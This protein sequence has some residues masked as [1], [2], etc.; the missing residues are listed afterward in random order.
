MKSPR[1]TSPGGKPVETLRTL[2]YEVT[3]RIA[4]VTLNQRRMAESGFREAVRDR[5]EAF[6]DA[7]RSTKD[8]GKE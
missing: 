7:G 1:N 5:D 3:G 4:R 6:G 8:A 2:T